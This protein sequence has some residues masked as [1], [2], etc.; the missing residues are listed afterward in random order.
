MKKINTQSIVQ[1]LI[2]LLL[3][4]NAAYPQN[5]SLVEDNPFLVGQWSGNGHFLD[6]DIRVKV[7]EIPVEIQISQDGNLSVKFDNYDVRDVKI[8]PAKYGFEIRGKLDSFTKNGVELK[9]DKLVI[10]LVLPESDKEFV[11]SSD[12]NFHLKSNFI[13]DFGMRVGGVKL[14]KR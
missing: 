8:F 14:K 13:F 2:I 1:W 7:G 5:L 6:S 9:K 11:T 10:L 4:P 3:F 12:S